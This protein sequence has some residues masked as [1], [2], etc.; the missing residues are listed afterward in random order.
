M[1]LIALTSNAMGSGKSTVALMLER[2]HQYT[3]LAFAGPIKRVSEA[4]FK[5]FGHCDADVYRFVYDDWKERE[6]AGLTISG[7]V[8]ASGYSLITDTLLYQTGMTSEQVQQA[9]YLGDD[10]IPAFGMSYS[11]IYARVI[12]FIDRH[13]PSD[14]P[15]TSRRWQQLFGTEF[16]REMIHPD[17]WVKIAMA[18]AATLDR[19]VID[20]MRFPNEFEAVRAAGGR[21]FRVHRPGTEVTSQ[22]ASEG[23]L[24]GTQMPTIYNTSTL[25]YLRHQVA[26]VAATLA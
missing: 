14:E 4:L 20:D 24:N 21:C 19:V 7:I 3:P 13:V 2:H 17:I 23:Q 8:A 5:A 11:S 26:E 25:E 10:I 9:G 22:H 12:L 16:G 18:K 6:V 1:N 15:L